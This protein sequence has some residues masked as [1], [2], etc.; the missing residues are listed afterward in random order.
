MVVGARDECGER[1]SKAWQN[2][3][4]EGYGRLLSRVLHGGKGAMAG[5]WRVSQSGG[6]KPKS[7]KEAGQ[8]SRSEEVFRTWVVAEGG[9]TCQAKQGLFL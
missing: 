4:D 8:G 6:G 7:Y 9:G 3:L 5:V 2:K 1:Q